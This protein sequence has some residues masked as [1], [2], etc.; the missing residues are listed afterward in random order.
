MR[1]FL[2]CRKETCAMAKR[3]GENQMLFR[4][5]RTKRGKKRSMMRAEYGLEVLKT[6]RLARALARKA[7]REASRSP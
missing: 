5:G 4:Q 1:K 2:R 7:A 3:E 6:P